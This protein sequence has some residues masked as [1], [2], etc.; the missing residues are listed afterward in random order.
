MSNSIG[1]KPL[2]E[3]QR[4]LVADN[5]GLVGVH[6]RRYVH[7]H[8]RLRREG[9]LDDLRQ[10][11]CLALVQAA[12][13]Y[14]AGCG[15]AFAA[16]ALRRIRNA[17]SRELGWNSRGGGGPAGARARGCAC[18]RRALLEFDPPDPR[19]VDRHRPD[20]AHTGCAEDEDRGERLRER[21]RRALDAA[22]RR[23]LNR[24]RPQP[25][26]AAVV[27]GVVEDRLLVG[28]PEHRASLR[29][30]ASE[31]GCPLAR[32]ARCERKLTQWAREELEQTADRGRSDCLD[33]AT[34]AEVQ[35]EKLEGKSE[36]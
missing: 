35:P 2:T 13:S 25:E 20:G 6:L 31:S 10:E 14:D 30:I 5:L 27:R 22:A 24:S 21:V 4:K 29:Q 8:G 36:K 28:D 15:V 7:G 19:S 26:D 1:E 33:G 9:R 16:Y 12:R 3:R 17:V 18:R 32:V 23:Y 34:V 11:G